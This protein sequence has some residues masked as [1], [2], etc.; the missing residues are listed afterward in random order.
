MRATVSRSRLVERKRIVDL[1]STAAFRLRELD[2]A[3]DVGDAVRDLGIDARA[4]GRRHRA[5]RRDEELGLDRARQPRLGQELLLVAV[6]DL[7][8]VALDV[9]SDDRLIEIALRV[10]LAD[11]HRRYRRGAATHAAAATAD[12]VARAGA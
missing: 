3:D 9:A 12:A 6:R 10:G 11:R 8:D 5:V 4:V 2:P 7:L 1:N